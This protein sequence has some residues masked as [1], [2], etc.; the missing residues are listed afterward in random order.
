MNNITPFVSKDAP[1]HMGLVPAS[2]AE[3]IKLAELMAG[4]KLVPK[5]FQNR[6]A[7][8][9]MV[10]QQAIRWDMDPFAVIGEC[11]VIQDKIMYSGKLVAAVVNTRGRLLD[12][13]A[14]SYQGTGD[15]L[16]IT[17]TG[18]LQG[19][20]AARDVTVRYA[21][22]KTGAAVWK[23]QP[24]QQLMYHGARVWARRHMP[25]LMLG[26]YSPEEFEPGATLDNGTNGDLAPRQNPHVTQPEDIVDVPPADHPDRIPDSDLDLKPLPVVRQRATHEELIKEKRD[27]KHVNE[28]QEWKKQV[29]NRMAAMSD[30]WKQYM[31]TEF[32]G[33]IAEVRAKE[34]TPHDAETGEVLEEA[35]WP[36]ELDHAYQQCE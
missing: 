25:E 18:R 3:A 34:A 36:T 19:E 29:P 22:A 4:S 13:L 23:S 32:V 1:P 7:D 5:Q 35:D 31:Q 30:K 24:E 10:I 28:M 17:V 20:I 11:S 26:V 6:P 21:N 33:Y 12:R 9:L 8:C 2:M 15:N 16:A 27:T 14:Y